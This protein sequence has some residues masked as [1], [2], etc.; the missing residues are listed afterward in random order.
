[1]PDTGKKQKRVP[2]LDRGG[3][4]SF[5]F[6][7]SSPAGDIDQS[8]PVKNPAV[9]LADEPTGNLDHKGADEIFALLR[10]Q[11]EKRGCTLIV[12]T[13]DRRFIQPQDNVVE[14][15]DGQIVG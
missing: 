9:L 8:E 10:E 3:K 4:L 11:Q 15:L 14:I 12:V 1:M 13:H 7:I 6:K 2:W 5:R